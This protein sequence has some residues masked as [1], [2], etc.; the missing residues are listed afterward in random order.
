MPSVLITYATGETHTATVANR[1]GDHLA[2][3]DIDVTVRTVGNVSDG[4]LSDYDGVLVGASIRTRHH[5]PDLV[6]FLERNSDVLADRPSGFFQ[7]SLAAAMPWAG[8][9]VDGGERVE[10]LSAATGWEPDLIGLFGGKIVDT[11]LGPVDRLLYRGAAAVAGLG[12]DTTPDSTGTDWEDVSAFADT[13]GDLVERTHA[14][15]VTSAAASDR[16]TRERLLSALVVGIGVAG[17][18]YLLVR[19]RRTDRQETLEDYTEPPAGTPA[20]GAA[21]AAETPDVALSHHEELA[22]D[23][24]DELN[25]SE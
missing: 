14:G 13:F 23:G 9:S 21:D 11:E 22:D 20:V 19:R 16:G 6:A 5:N 10:T 15:M 3:R 18:T 17:L 4:E 25:S 12:T 7:L 2:T 1:L 24:D 8:P